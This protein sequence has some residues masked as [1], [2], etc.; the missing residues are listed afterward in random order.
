MAV[1]S[2]VGLV[3]EKSTGYLKVTGN[4]K[5]GRKSTNYRINIE[6]LTPPA[7]GTPSTEKTSEN[8]TPDLGPAHAHP[9]HSSDSRTII[10]PS[11]NHQTTAPFPK[12]KVGRSITAKTLMP[13]LFEISQKVRDWAVENGYDQLD[14]HLSYFREKCQA[15]GY[16]YLNW[17]SG[18]KLAIMK[19]WAGL[20]QHHSAPTKQPCSASATRYAKDV[21][22]PTPRVCGPSFSDAIGESE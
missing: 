12:I 17:D 2:R 16:K 21:S 7:E 3:A 14:A 6:M 11:I 5:G 18:F 22:P 9:L 15:K 1:P 20:R 19:N 4:S 13:R 10:E 8:E